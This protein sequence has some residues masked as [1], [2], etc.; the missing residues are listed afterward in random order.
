[1]NRQLL[2]RALA[3]IFAAT[4]LWAAV[5]G[6]KSL[7]FRDAAANAA[8]SF[9]AAK[10]ILRWELG[11]YFGT[12]LLTAANVLAL[13]QS[14]LLL[15]QRSAIVPLMLLAME[16][17]DSAKPPEAVTTPESAPP[18][19]P[20]STAISTDGLSFAP[21]GVPSQTVVP[22]STKGYT[23]VGNAYIKNTSS[24]TLDGLELA[25][26][27]TPVLPETDGP[28]V[29]IVHSH[30]TEAYTM[31]KGQEYE[32]SGTYR[33]HDTACNVVRVGDEVAAVLSGYGISVLHDRTLHD[34]ASYND[35]YN[36]SYA[37]IKRYLEKYPTIRYV[38]DL[39][40]DAIQDTN[41]NQYKLIAREDT[42]VAQCCLVMGL[43]HDGWS[44]NLRLAVAVQQ[45]LTDLSP[46][47]MRPI[48]ARGYRYNQHL[49][50]G[51][52]LVEVG[53]AG[54]SLDEAL[55]AAR[56]F[57]TGFANTILPPT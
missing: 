8:G 39:H 46:T 42:R 43:A 25:Q 57:A 24:R 30:A 27:V 35:A 28:L 12:D 2:R 22:T 31:P 54:N 51:S 45:Q 47:L 32:P 52:L 41:G 23:V 16:Q 3:L 19:P 37:S 11:D 26:P 34:A 56:Y 5:I 49:H 17:V 4:A 50:P 29:L 55:L 38:L 7:T 1:M 21:N 33:T 20:S 6:S 15:K 44:D 36:S 48:A 40:R 18:L 14:P 13:Q 53:A 9:D 10:R